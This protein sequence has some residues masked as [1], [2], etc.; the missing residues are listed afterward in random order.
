MCI[1]DRCPVKAERL[2][3]FLSAGS[4]KPT[5]RSTVRN[6]LYFLKS[7]PF[8]RSIASVIIVGHV[9]LIWPCTRYSASLLSSFLFTVLSKTVGSSRRVP[10]NFSCSSLLTRGSGVPISSLFSNF[11]LF[12]YLFPDSFYSLPCVAP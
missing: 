1:R 9:T 8:I 2:C 7:Y 4:V 3:A 6:S 11:S 5:K 10:S 12:F